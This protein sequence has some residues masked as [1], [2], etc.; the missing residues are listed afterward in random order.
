MPI[1]RI[2]LSIVV[3]LS[4]AGAVAAFPLGGG[5]DGTSGNIEPSEYKTHDDLLLEAGKRIPEF[6]GLYL[7]DDRTVLYVYVNDGAEDTLNKA[8]VKGAVDD[9]LKSGLTDGRELRL[10]SAQFSMLQL[11]GWYSQIT[12][13]VSGDANVVLTDLDESANR[14][15]IGVDSLD[16]TETLE[17]SLAS[18]N[19]P[20]EAVVIQVRERPTPATHTLRSRATGDVMEGGYQIT[21]TGRGACTL[22]FNVVRDG[23]A[24]L[25]T[26]GHCTEASPWDGG[27]DNTAFYQPNSATNSTSIGEE[28]IDPSFSSSPSQCPTGKVCR[29]SD[30]A[31]IEG[32]SGLS[33]NLGKIAKTT[34]QGGIIINHNS[35]FRIV[36]ENTLVLFQSEYAG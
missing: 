30:S 16:A 21:G 25:V 29:Y 28:T 14:I 6:G 3:V 34:A 27:V 33:Q 17:A 11:Y 24:G 12:G 22:G 26:A 13:L 8:E 7:S 5:S 4:I 15:E 20:G 36:G 35:K 32:A 1:K 2:V 18:A 31:F 23:E 19:I 10:V 9:V